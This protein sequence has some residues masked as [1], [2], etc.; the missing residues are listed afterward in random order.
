MTGFS[1]GGGGGS[2][3][4]GTLTIPG[5]SYVAGTVN[6]RRAVMAMGG[7]GCGITGEWPSVSTG[8]SAGAYT[9]TF[10]AGI[11]ALLAVG[12][13]IAGPGLGA[14]ST[15]TIASIA[16]NTVTLSSGA[17]NPT[18]GT[19]TFY[20][21]A[22]TGSD[23]CQRVGFTIP[24]TGGAPIGRF[25]LR[26]RN[27]CLLGNGVIPGSITL[28]GVYMGTPNSSSETSW[29]GDFTAAPTSLGLSGANEMGSSEYVSG[30]ISPSTYALTP[31]AFTGLSIG[32]TC[33]GV[34]VTQDPM[35]GWTWVGTGAGSVGASA[36]AAPATGVGGVTA[37]TAQPLLVYLDVRIEYE[38]QG[39]NQIGFVVGDSLAAGY[40]NATTATGHMGPD[41]TW[42]QKAGLRLGH[43]LMNGGVGGTTATIYD[44]AAVASTLAF[45]RF[46][47]PDGSGNG[48]NYTGFACTPDYAVIAL[49][50]NDAVDTGT[51][52]LSGYQT[53]ML[54]LL[55]E[56]R[57]A[58]ISR[59]YAVTA[60]PGTNLVGF[61]NPSFE[62]GQ[63][64]VALNAATPS[65]ITIEG[66][67][68]GPGAGQPG[69]A[70]S[71]YLGAGGPYNLYIG[72]PQ[73]PVTNGGPLP[74]IA[75]ATV[76]ETTTPVA[77]SS[78]SNSGATVTVTLAA[79]EQGVY[80][81]GDIVTFTGVT[82]SGTYPALMNGIP[83][84]VVGV[85]ATTCKVTLSATPT[86]TF[87]A[88][89]M[90]NLSQVTGKTFMGLGVTA[91]SAVTA[92][93]GTPV[94]TAS[95][96]NR[97]AINLWLR[98]QPPGIEAIIDFDADVTSQFYFPPA[99]GRAEYYGGTG[100]S[101][102]PTGPGMYDMVASR[103]VNGIL[104]N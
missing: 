51:P 72:T 75:A 48:A 53:A 5:Q 43:H 38:F 30:W 16:S 97:Q 37:A 61:L 56:L 31:G 84:K 81:D 58:G 39:S 85:T 57:T 87:T 74:V 36:A 73:N 77:V 102:H 54:S 70:S 80:G 9:I 15:V 63:L 79:G 13:G 6:T 94:L 35:P 100:G 4:P 93:E 96:W 65:V 12:Q 24:A 47:N 17:A 44:S 2:S 7:A 41:N 92:P 26:I 49:G 88:G 91:S 21:V 95:E 33:S 69:P 86:G 34:K 19:Y 3:T 45:T 83:F 27:A 82:G 11:T 28:S 98:S 62:A 103:F 1:N 23:V 71:W 104:G 20:G 25:R 89:S 40:L 46:F 99:T 50:V 60:T 67:A 59:S 101:V 14:P 68:G 22:P 66:P 90:I 8:G 32:F 52:A 29:S 78:V 64:A 76:S 10:A 18:G 42:P 55:G